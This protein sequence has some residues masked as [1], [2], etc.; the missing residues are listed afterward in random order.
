MVFHASQLK[1]FHGDT[2]E[3]PHFP[4]DSTAI[5]ISAAVVASK[6]ATDA[7]TQILVQWS[8][9]YPEDATWE[10]LPDMMATFPKLHLEDKVFSDANDDVMYQEEEQIANEEDIDAQ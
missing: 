1:P 7:P 2:D 4:S 6:S 5:P 8:N 9:A 10:S 3:L